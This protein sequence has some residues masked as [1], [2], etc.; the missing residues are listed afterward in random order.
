MPVKHLAYASQVDL[1][2]ANRLI[3][4]DFVPQ[5]RQMRR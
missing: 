5:T 3:R 4:Y 1:G 2:N